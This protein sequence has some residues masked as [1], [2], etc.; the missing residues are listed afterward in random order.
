MAGTAGDPGRRKLPPFQL[1]LCPDFAR[2]IGHHRSS[3]VP[4][5]EVDDT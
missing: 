2:T 1:R 5:Q 4:V 3:S